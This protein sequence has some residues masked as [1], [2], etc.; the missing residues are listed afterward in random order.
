MEQATILRSRFVDKGY[1]TEELDVIRLEVGNMDRAVILYGTGK[2]K[3]VKKNH[4]FSFVTTYSHQYYDIK[5]P[6]PN[7]GGY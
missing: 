4:I 2:P 7:I 1:R 3:T 6:C 5:K